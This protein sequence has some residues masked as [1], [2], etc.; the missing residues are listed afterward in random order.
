MSFGQRHYDWEE[1]DRQLITLL[2]GLNRQAPK[3]VE[4][5]FSGGQKIE[6]ENLGF[7]WTEAYLGRT[8]GYIRISA[9]FYYYN[10]SIVTYKIQPDLPFDSSLQKMYLAWYA[11]LYT[12]VDTIRYQFGNS[13]QVIFT[14]TPFIFNGTGI[15]HP[16]KECD[17]STKAQE[18][19]SKI[20]ECMSPESGIQYGFGGGLP[21]TV[22]S[23]RKVFEEIKNKLSKKEIVA[24]LYSINP[25]SRLM[26][27][28]YCIQKNDSLLKDP[29]IA[30]WVEKLYREVPQVQTM[31]GC[32][33]EMKD[34]KKL[35][36]RYAKI[37]IS[38]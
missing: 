10:D 13:M 6:K 24:L 5:F 1:S 12:S 7:G 37:N 28:E 29:I 31:S 19:S 11:P 36:E 25:A 23:N 15:L 32:I 17:D 33:V 38:Q 21:F 27:V 2:N 26:A 34:S 14:M 3:E 35:V 18:L 20:L 22:F 4:Q 16:L 9:A 30:K 8:A